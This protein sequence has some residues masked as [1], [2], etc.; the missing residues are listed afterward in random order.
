MRSPLGHYHFYAAD[1]E[2]WVGRLGPAEGL[3]CAEQNDQELCPFIMTS[4]STQGHSG[5]EEVRLSC[6]P[7]ASSDIRIK[8]MLKL[9]PEKLQGP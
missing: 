8:A 3:A 5:T 2:A 7:M 1:E 6:I 9:E 4:G